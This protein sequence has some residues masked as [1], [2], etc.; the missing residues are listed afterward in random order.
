MSDPES[1][2]GSVTVV[3]GPPGQ[4]LSVLSERVKV[5][6]HS[7]RD[8]V[9]SITESEGALRN[10]I[11]ELEVSERSLQHKV[12]D[13]TA[14]SA[15]HCPRM[16]R[17][18]LDERLYALKDE[19]RTM[20][21]EKE[22][23]ERVWR[24]RLQRCQAQL[25]AK[26]EEMARQS[27]YFEHFKTQLQQKLS[28]SRD[29]EQGL[30][31]RIHLLERRLLELTVSAASAA[32]PALKKT[33]TERLAHLRGEGE[34][35][36][37]GE[38][39]EEATERRRGVG[40]RSQPKP[41]LPREGEREGGRADVVKG[42]E[43]TEDRGMKGL[44][45]E[46]EGRARYDKE[47]SGGEA[48]LRGFILSL[49][50]DLRALLE[51]EEQGE[52][53]RRGLAEQLQEA[54]ENSHF[55]SCKM[56]EMRAGVH[57]LKLAESSLTEE[58]EELQEENLRLHRSLGQNPRKASQTPVPEGPSPSPSPNHNSSLS[59]APVV[60]Q[61]SPPPMGQ[62]GPLNCSDQ[63]E[64]LSLLSAPPS[65]NHRG[66][67]KCSQED[68]TAKQH[69][70]AKPDSS[71][72]PLPKPDLLNLS[73]HR[74]PKPKPSP[75]P[76]LLSLVT[77]TA[78]VGAFS[79]SQGDSL[80]DWGPGFP[81]LGLG[82]A[83]GSEETEAL[84]EAY[85]SL[86]GDLDG[87]RDQRDQLENALLHTQQQL[88]RLSLENARLKLQLREQAGEGAS[89]A[90]LRCSVG[91]V[92]VSGNSQIHGHPL[93]HAPTQEVLPSSSPSTPPEGD[94]L[95]L[96]QDDL[97]LA[98]NQE[99]RA[100][101]GRIQELL[102][103]LELQEG[104]AERELAQLRL[105]VLGLERD[106]ARLEQDNEEQVCLIAELTRKTEDDLNTIM[107]L[108]QRLNNSGQIRGPQVHD[109]L[110][111]GRGQM[112]LP[113][114][115]AT[116]SESG[117][118]DRDGGSVNGPPQSEGPVKPVSVPS[119][120]NRAVVSV[121]IQPPEPATELENGLRVD[122]S[123]VCGQQN[124]HPTTE[125]PSGPNLD[126]RVVTS[127]NPPQGEDGSGTASGSRGERSAA[128]ELLR[129]VSALR[130]EQRELG[131]SL[132]GQ[133]DDKHQL[134]RSL[135]VL[136]EE[137]DQVTLSLQALKQERDLLTRSLC[138]VREERDK[139][140]RSMSSL[141]EERDRLS[142]SVGSL[143]EERDHFVS[144]KEREHVTQSLHGLEKERDQVERSLC[145]LKEERDQLTR[146]MCTLNEERDALVQSL[147]DL[148]EE[149]D[150]LAT[151]LC[152]EKEK[153]DQ[154]TNSLRG[155]REERDRLQT[156]VTSLQKLLHS[157]GPSQSR[158]ANQSQDGGSEGREELPGER[159]V[160]EEEGES[161]RREEGHSQLMRE[162]E[163]TGAELRRSQEELQ[164]SQSEVQRCY[165]ELGVSEA[166]SVEAEKRAQQAANDVR[167]MREGAK[168]EEEETNREHDKLRT[169][170][171]EMHDRVTRLQREK[172]DALSL[173][174]QEEEH[175][176]MLQAQLN[177][178]TVALQELNLEYTALRR[179]KESREEQKDTFTSLRARYDDIRAKY[180]VLLRK[181]SQTD[182]DMAPLKAKLSCLVVKCQQRNRVLA[183]MMR[184]LRRSGCLDLPLI[185]EAEDLL[186]DTALQDYTTTFSPGHKTTLPD[187]TQS[188]SSPAPQ[189]DSGD[190]TSLCLTS[191]DQSP[192]NTPLTQTSKV[193]PVQVTASA[194]R[195]RLYQEGEKGE[196]PERWLGVGRRL[197][198]PEKIMNLQLQLQ[199]TLFQSYQASVRRVEAGE[200]E[201]H[202]RGRASGQQPRIGLSV[203]A[204]R[205]MTLAPRT[206]VNVPIS[207][208]APN[209]PKHISSI[210]TLNKASV[211]S[212]PKHAFSGTP[213]AT[214]SAEESS[215]TRNTPSVVTM[216]ITPSD[217]GSLSRPAP[218][219]E[220]A[221]T[222]TTTSVTPLS[223]TP[224]RST[225][226]L[227][228]PPLG[229]SAPTL[230]A[231]TVRKRTAT[232]SFKTAPRRTA[233]AT[234]HTPNSQVPK[235][236]ARC[237]SAP[238]TPA[239]YSTLS[240]SR[241][242]APPSRGLH[243]TPATPPSLG[244]TAHPERQ[245]GVSHPSSARSNRAKQEAPAEVGSV[246]VIK[247]VGQSSLMIGW[248][249]P[250]LDELGC[251]NGT[252]VYGY[253]IHVNGEF[254]KSVMSSA[255]TKCILENVDL[256][257]PVHI[258]VQTLGTNGLHAAKVSAVHRGNHTPFR[259]DPTHTGTDHSLLHTDPASSGQRTPITH[260]ESG[261]N[262]PFVA[263]YSY[264]P[265][266]DSPNLHP[267]RELALH[268][269]DTVTL[270]GNPRHDGFCEAE[271]NGRRGLAPIAFL[272]EVSVPVRPGNPAPPPST[273]GRG[274]A[275]HCDDQSERRATNRPE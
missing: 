103:H 131:R 265:L 159:M 201:N 274:S 18:R 140:M 212:R 251:S 221:A 167:R 65:L 31:A 196:A 133:T 205:E 146:S 77:S 107:D 236:V 222:A 136:K 83:E 172:S 46:E 82:E 199:N 224:T 208:V 237:Q 189:N 19:V 89:E 78:E 105:Q 10:R 93:S 177:A 32:V 9:N 246:D 8:K 48:R 139:M 94:L 190:D 33:A 184:A 239:P 264:S 12:D 143:K 61:S 27:H 253:R 178:K 15:L 115:H 240:D 147:C 6:E 1:G 259:I 170:V 72:L 145:G 213:T 29:R 28:L 35:E 53:E 220:K 193:G 157:E 26:E 47:E 88:Q 108:Q 20:S 67:A 168:E 185:L 164:R 135:W 263:V 204:T 215:P 36:E 66:T 17:Q 90:E 21:Q 269:G 49:Q 250:P 158:V 173:K 195:H 97:A 218:R 79:L 228:F 206:T 227:S 268:E 112:E 200:V 113:S 2:S 3:T 273:P 232:A 25:K 96:A 176:T 151:S 100:L 182:L 165:H 102:A 267:S 187:S 243:S 37:G 42:G 256:C 272:E 270:L 60:P 275:D 44:R 91:E 141:K 57:R 194:D 62:P 235:P 45:G 43:D 216:T 226:P 166:R 38:E 155:L 161:G 111:S 122:P 242:P 183:Q 55:L 132:Q 207:T 127:G 271:L 64:G 52:A 252:F 73:G 11:R 75:K 244:K 119:Q 234:N 99:N 144:E 59:S 210:P 130:E 95:A 118:G 92:R 142:Q 22:R 51:R 153:K 23:G 257:G 71:T 174:A 98:L 260:E 70:T 266:R 231:Q 230:M 223:S 233:P 129:S 163:A 262:R 179:E 68:D 126:D 229:L 175:L 203:P 121:H 241:T 40:R 58:V 109:A 34:G 261:S 171:R 114:D 106:G 192:L 41:G 137:R 152:G 5:L 104:E 123:P 81:S 248:E 117:Q 87:L 4:A 7:L 245:R 63:Q 198:S 202:T 188:L 169:E 138:G 154:L 156:D 120:V 211:T 225:A 101:A 160:R 180:D 86:G 219:T 254:H 14:T 125:L 191:A 84:R 258:A 150:K 238:D 209:Q 181:K 124:K 110:E 54:Q 217:L 30:Q 162:V 148:E 76:S 69:T 50:E 197:S 85:R 149:R 186:N 24:V 249:R 13:L 255:C 39:E 214:S 134:T 116:G 74:S 128:E 247:T 80:G 16:Q 56:E